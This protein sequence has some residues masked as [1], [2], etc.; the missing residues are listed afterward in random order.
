MSLGGMEIMVIVVL[1]LVLFGPDKLPELA[2]G[3][4][5]GMREIRKITGEFQNQLS[6]IGED[7]PEKPRPPQA[8]AKAHSEADEAANQ[9][10]EKTE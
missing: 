4:G 8:S 3:V 2:R 10:R 1:V 6:M 9:D 5:R 7:E